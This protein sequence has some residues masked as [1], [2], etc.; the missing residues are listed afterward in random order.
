MN[1]YEDPGRLQPGASTQVRVKKCF[2]LRWLALE[3]KAK[4]DGMWTEVEIID[5]GPVDISIIMEKPM[6]FLFNFHGETFN[7]LWTLRR[8]ANVWILSREKQADHPLPA[9]W[10]GGEERK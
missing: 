2:D 5:K 7:A 6:G 8:K 1:I 9:T 10:S 4:V 3:G